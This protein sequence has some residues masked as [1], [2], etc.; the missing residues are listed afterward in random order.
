MLYQVMQL[1]FKALERR[2][3][4]SSAINK[5]YSSEWYHILF[6]GG[7]F[8]IK[9]D[10]KEYFLWKKDNRLSATYKEFQKILKEFLDVT[11]SK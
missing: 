4:V 5:G 3:L 2:I 7:T 1:L 8:T 11:F 6:S 10:W 9:K